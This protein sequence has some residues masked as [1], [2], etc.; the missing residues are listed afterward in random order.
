MARQGYLPN[1]SGVETPVANLN[2]AMLPYMSMW[3]T[4]NGPELLVKGLPSGVALAYGNP[5]QSIREDF[6]N[7]RT[8]LHALALATLFPLFT[9]WTMARI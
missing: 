8:R 1:A 4:P 3:P 9:P 2:P 5:R 6:G 7:L